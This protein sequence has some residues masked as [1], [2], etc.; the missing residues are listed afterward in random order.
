MVKWLRRRVLSAESWV[1]SPLEL[2]IS[3]VPITGMRLFLYLN[4]Y[5]DPHWSYVNS[6]VSAF[7]A[8]LYKKASNQLR[9]DAFLILINY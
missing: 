8:R 1:R 3:L 7:I 4:A 2:L 9:V 5:I 6:L